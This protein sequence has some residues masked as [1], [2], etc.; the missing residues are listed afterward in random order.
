MDQVRIRTTAQMLAALA[1]GGEDP[2]RRAEELIAALAADPRWTPT[3]I[4]GVRTR[5]EEYLFSGQ[6]ASGVF[7]LS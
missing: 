3:D 7:L 1:A 4:T 5:V 6:A 2:C